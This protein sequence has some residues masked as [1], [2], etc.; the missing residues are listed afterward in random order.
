[1]TVYNCQYNRLLFLIPEA[2]SEAA[3]RVQAGR[4]PPPQQRELESAH[5]YYVGM[6]VRRRLCDTGRHTRAEFAGHR[7]GRLLCADEGRVGRPEE[8]VCGV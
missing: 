3:G 2:R 5:V 6:R 1:M 7:N 4:Q 8:T